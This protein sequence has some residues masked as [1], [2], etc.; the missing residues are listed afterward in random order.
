M[1]PKPTQVTPI[2]SNN[3]HIVPSGIMP[4]T[5]VGAMLLPT[6]LKE[7]ALLR[8]SLSLYVIARPDFFPVIFVT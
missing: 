8:T 2:Q 7:M 3:F 5:T 1:M 6:F 4:S